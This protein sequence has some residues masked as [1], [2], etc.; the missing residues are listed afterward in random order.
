MS[1]DESKSSVDKVADL[2]GSRILCTLDDGRKLEGNFDHHPMYIISCC[3]E[4]IMYIG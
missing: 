2:L 1:A 4:D 3:L